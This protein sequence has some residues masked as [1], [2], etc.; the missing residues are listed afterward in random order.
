MIE[1]TDEKILEA[2][3]KQE[4]EGGTLPLLLDFYRKLLRIQSNTRRGIGILEPTIS[5]GAIE[6]RLQRGRPLVAFDEL[7]LDWT[8]MR[9][10]FV[11]VINVFSK[12]PQLFVELPARLR[13]PSAGKLLTKKAVKAWFTGK[14]LPLALVEDTN[15]NLIQT[16]IQYTMHPFLTAHAETLISSVPFEYWRQGYCPICG[17]SPDISYLEKEVGARWLKCSRCDSEWLF[18]RMECP[19]CRTN[20]QNSL[21]FLSDD[22]YVYRL[23][24]CEQCKCY[25]KTIDLRKTDNE[26]LLPLERIQTLDLDAQAKDRGYHACGTVKA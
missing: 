10:A 24:L 13:S 20:D 18:N 17:G 15:E 9:Q 26:V 14:E 19:F 8:K 4:T 6:A 16:I 7:A 5:T 1:D 3:R 2:L 11:D 22:A 23:Y 21:S 12:Y 25:L